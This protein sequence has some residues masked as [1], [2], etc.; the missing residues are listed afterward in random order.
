MVSGVDLITAEDSYYIAIFYKDYHKEVETIMSH[1][2]VFLDAYY[3][4]NVWQC[5]SVPFKIKMN[6]FF[7][8]ETNSV[9]AGNGDPTEVKWNKR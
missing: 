5:F 4:K 8:R 7:D 6:D 1:L 3:S 9:V 2:P